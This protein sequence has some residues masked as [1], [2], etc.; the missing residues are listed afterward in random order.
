MK[1]SVIFKCSI[2]DYEYV[3]KKIFESGINIISSKLKGKEYYFIVYEDDYN[4]LSRY[5]YKKVIVFSGYYGLFNII[6]II[7]K[8]IIYIMST[9]VVIL[10][11]F[12]S[13]FFILKVDIHTN[14]K[15]LSLL[16]K[17]YLIDNKIDDFSLKKDF[18]TIKTI[19]ENLLKKYSD[20]I[21]WI[22][23]KNNGYKYDIY[24]IERKKNKI[25]SESDRCNYVAKKSGTIT[26]IKA[27][28]GVL[29][30]QE[31]NYVNV[32]DILIGGSI[33]YND[34]LK[35]EVCAKGKIYGEVWYEVQVSYPMVKTYN[36]SNKNKFYN[37]SLRMFGNN[38]KIFKSKYNDEKTIKKIGNEK[39]GINIISST[40]YS[41]KNRVITEEQATKLALNKASENIIL[42]SHNKSKVLSQNIL[43]KY[44]NNGTIY[45]KVLITAEEELGVV[46]NY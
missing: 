29:L 31:N 42:K 27:T 14:N 7:K 40:K 4:I 6:N 23:I 3:L 25:I 22:E 20:E 44:V 9:L 32:G 38:Y 16:I 34:E 17:Y 12:L 46:E 45:M 10:I 18:N 13:N 33:I 37:I 15:N 19:K 35:K 21:E 36:V 11:L 26:K 2:L 28:K 39:F 43:K 8:N 41:K 1:Y 24:V 5:D 30:V